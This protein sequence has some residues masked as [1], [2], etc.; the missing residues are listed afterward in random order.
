MIRVEVYPYCHQCLKFIP[1]VEKPAVYYADND[2]AAASDTVIR[3]TRR[4][5]CEILKKYLEEQMKDKPQS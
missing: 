1:D 4:H 5:T 3:C 2:I